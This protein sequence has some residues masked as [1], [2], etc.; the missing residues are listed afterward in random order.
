MV[1]RNQPAVVPISGRLCSAIPGYSRRPIR[2]PW[3]QQTTWPAAGLPSSPGTTRT[4]TPVCSGR[5]GRPP[6]SPAAPARHAGRPV[7]STGNGAAPGPPVGLWDCCSRW[8]QSAAVGR[9]VKCRRARACRLRRHGRRQ[10][11]S[12]VVSQLP[13]GGSNGRGRD[14]AGLRERAGGS[15]NNGSAVTEVR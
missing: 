13:D 4:A 8:G 7:R 14:T 1:G 12:S 9:R 3:L 10:Q 2:L 5:T 6:D 15:D 11:Q